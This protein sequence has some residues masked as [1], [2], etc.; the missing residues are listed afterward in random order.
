MYS[1]YIFKTLPILVRQ[2][3][4]SQ[5][6][7]LIALIFKLLVLVIYELSSLTFYLSSVYILIIPIDINHKLSN[8]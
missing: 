8:L 5:Y 6:I 3:S 7:C 2:S 4:I 1:Y